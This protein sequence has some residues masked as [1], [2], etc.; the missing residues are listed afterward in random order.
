MALERMVAVRAQVGATPAK[1][2]SVA[3]KDVY[4]IVIAATIWVSKWTRKP[5]LFYC[6]NHEVVDIWQK[7]TTKEKHLMQLVR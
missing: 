5:L 1:S 6:D 3:W 2:F 4:A 7:K